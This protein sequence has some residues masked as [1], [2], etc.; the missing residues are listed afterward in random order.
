[1]TELTVNN[2]FRTLSDF[3]LNLHAPE[4]LKPAT[5]LVVCV[6]RGRDF[7][8]TTKAFEWYERG[9][10]R[11]DKVANKYNHGRLLFR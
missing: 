5:T 9:A 4:V 10:E 2:P 11:G 3:S 7:L 6:K 8:D 1:M